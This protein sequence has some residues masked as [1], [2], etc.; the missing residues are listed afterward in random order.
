MTSSAEGLPLAASQ[1]EKVL[2]MQVWAQCVTVV[3]RQAPFSANFD[4]RRDFTSDGRS[5]ISFSAPI[6]SVSAAKLSP[7]PCCFR[8][9]TTKESCNWCAAGS[10]EPCA[11]ISPEKRG[12]SGDNCAS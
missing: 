11:A 6:S 3:K 1:E 9:S 7:I 2:R 12:S 10:K 5:K 8:K 4:K